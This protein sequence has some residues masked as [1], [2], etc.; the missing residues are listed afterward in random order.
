LREGEGLKMVSSD[1]KVEKFMFYEA[2]PTEGSKKRGG[3]KNE[4]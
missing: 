3:V 2:G 1:R 4:T